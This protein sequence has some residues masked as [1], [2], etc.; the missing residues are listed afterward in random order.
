MV[1]YGGGGSEHAVV[2]LYNAPIGTCRT[3]QH[4]ERGHA[5]LG[6][7]HR[8]RWRTDPSQRNSHARAAEYAEQSSDERPRWAMSSSHGYL[9]DSIFMVMDSLGRPGR[10]L[11]V[12]EEHLGHLRIHGN[13]SLTRHS[14]ST[15]P[16]QCACPQSG[17][18]WCASS[19]QRSGAARAPRCMRRR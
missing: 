7:M 4:G 16:W 6:E 10:L 18:P 8:R 15:G 9:L 17:R 1:Q 13:F 19:S 12:A 11:G 14:S 2:E 3:S 5:L